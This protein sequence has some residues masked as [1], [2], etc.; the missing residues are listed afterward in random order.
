MSSDKNIKV[1]IV[2]DDEVML[3]TLELAFLEGPYTV[4]TV[5]NPFKAYQM[6]ENMHFDV[7]VCDIVMPGMDGLT[8]LEKIKNYNGMIQVIMITAEITV[9]NAIKAF[10]KGAV[11]IFFKPFKQID[12]VVVA[13]DEAAKKL[14]RVN[15]VLRLATGI[16]KG[17]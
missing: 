1:L 12:E 14:A 3:S 9:N 10:R 15:A 17:V 2:D 11:D 13:V 4:T 6:V 8:L 16:D 5:N 7:V